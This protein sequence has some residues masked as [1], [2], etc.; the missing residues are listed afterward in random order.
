MASAGVRLP[1][2]PLCGGAKKYLPNIWERSEQRS[3]VSSCHLPCYTAT[4]AGRG[5][6]VIWRRADVGCTTRTVPLDC[7]TASTDKG[8]EVQQKLLQREKKA[9]DDN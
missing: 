6:S 9:K 5:T 3:E 7:T 4:A 8:L 2:Y 1:A